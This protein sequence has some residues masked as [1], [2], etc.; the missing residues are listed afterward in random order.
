MDHQVRLQRQVLKRRAGADV[1]GER[2]LPAGEG[3]R[4]HV[5][6]R[7]FEI[8]GDRLAEI[9]VAAEE[10]IGH[11]GGGWLLRPRGG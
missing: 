10:E 3:K 8:P 5:P 7:G 11:G 6:A 4:D 1:A 9:A 2:V